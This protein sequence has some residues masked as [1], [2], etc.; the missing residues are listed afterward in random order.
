MITKERRIKI[1]NRK[2]TVPVIKTLSAPC[3]S[4]YSYQCYSTKNSDSKCTRFFIAFM[5]LVCVS[6][7]ALVLST[8]YVVSYELY[9]LWF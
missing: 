9:K 4:D 8:Y 7:P 6:L 3:R 2:Q 1:S 5:Y